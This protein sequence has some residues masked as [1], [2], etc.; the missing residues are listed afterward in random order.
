[1]GDREGR[2]ARRGRRGPLV[3]VGGVSSA[4]ERVLP[5]PGGRQRAGL[6]LQGRACAAARS[7]R[8]EVEGGLSGSGRPRHPR[9]AEP[10]GVLDRR[11][12][13]RA[14]RGA[15]AV[16]AARGRVHA[17]ATRV[18]PITGRKVKAPASLSARTAMRLIDGRSLGG[19]SHAAAAF[20]SGAARARSGRSSHARSRQ[21]PRPCCLPACSARWA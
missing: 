9:G 7:V 21:P 17:G 18:R 2:R 16:R 8:L 1:M 14:P 4:V 12:R 15:L 10:G 3:Q 11:R 13:V 20:S 19:R 5:D 6:L